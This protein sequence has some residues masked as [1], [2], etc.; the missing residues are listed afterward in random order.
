M[1]KVSV[2]YPNNE[3]SSFNMDYY[4]NSHF[5]MLKDRLGDACTG[6]AVEAGLGGGAPD[7]PATYIAMGHIYFDSMESFQA[8]FGPHADEI[9]GDIP[10]YTDIEPIIQVSEV[11]L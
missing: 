10:N 4:L 2:L 3:G 6:V 5:P 11:K 9:M 7:A 8:A 1:I